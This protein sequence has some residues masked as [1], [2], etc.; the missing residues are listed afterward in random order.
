MRT[1]F[2]REQALEGIAREVITAYDPSLY[3]GAPTMIPI[4][5]MEH[6]YTGM[7]QQRS[8]RK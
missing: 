3:Y 6:S 2:Y 4:E 8:L 7:P 1:P 5:N